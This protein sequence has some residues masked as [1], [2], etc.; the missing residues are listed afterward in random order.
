MQRVVKFLTTTIRSWS[1]LLTGGVTV[2]EEARIV[3]TQ[4]KTA[5]VDAEDLAELETAMAYNEAALVYHGTFARLN[6]VAHG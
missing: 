5:I 2:A 6:D 4:G 1:R 3:L